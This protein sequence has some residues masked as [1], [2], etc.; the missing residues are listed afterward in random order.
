MKKRIIL[1]VTILLLAFYA[2]ANI[3]GA[4]VVPVNRHKKTS[5]VLT[6]GDLA[7][8]VI[9]STRNEDITIDV[10]VDS[11]YTEASW[12]VWDYTTSTYYFG[13]DQTFAAAYEN[14]VVTIPLALG[15]YSVHC[16]DAFGDGGIEGIVTDSDTNILVTW[17]AGDYLFSGEFD[18]TVSTV[19]FTIDLTDDFG[20]GWNGGMLDLSVNG[21]IVLDDITL[22]TGSGPETF[23]FNV[24]DDDFVEIYYTAGGWPYENAYYVY[25]NNGNLA[26]SSGDGGVEPDAYI[27]FTV[28]I[29]P[30]VPAVFFSEYIE[31]SSNNKGFEIYNNEGV[32][33]NL[34]DFRVN[35]SA[36]GGGWEYQHYFPVGA[37]LDFID[38]WSIC[39]DEADPALQAVSDEILAYPSVVH[40]NGNDARG[41]EW[42]P[43]GGVTWI[44]IDIIGIPDEDPGTGW[45]VAG[46]AD[47]TNDHTL[48]R[49]DAINAGNTDWVASAGTEPADSEWLV[50]IQDTYDY[51]GWH[52][53]PPPPPPNPPQNLFVDELGYAT[54]E[55]PAAAPEVIAHHNGYS[56]LG[57]GTGASED[58]ICAAR[59]NAD[60][61]AAYYDIFEITAVSVHIRSADFSYV[62]IKVW[63]GGSFGD[64]GTEVYSSDITNSILIEDWTTHTLIT[65]IPLVSG[66]EYWIG[67]DISVTGDSPSSIDNGPAISGKG[68]WMYYDGD[69]LELL[70]F[71]FNYNWCI[72]GVI[73]PVTDGIVTKGDRYMISNTRNMQHSNAP[74]RI[75]R[76]YNTTS[77]RDFRDLLGYNIYLDGVF[78]EYTT[79]LF[80]QYTGLLA[81][82]TYLSEVT[83]VYDEG[84]SDPIEY[85]FVYNP[86]LNPPQNLDV[87]CIE[88][89]AHFIWEAP[90]VDTGERK[91]STKANKENN[92]DLTGYSVYLDQIEVATNI[93]DLEYDFY[94]LIYGNFYDAGVKAIY[95]EGASEL[96]EI[97]FQYTGT[98]VENILP[99][100]TELTG[101][102][103]NPFNPITII[104]YSLAEEGNIELIVFNIKGQQVKTLINEKLP[105]GNHQVMWDGKDEY[106]KPVSSGIYFYKMNTSDYTSVKKMILMK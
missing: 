75:E 37:T 59:F 53:I 2:F 25:D 38:V 32:A 70:S 39:T 106:S 54:W 33:I 23:V 62:A 84:E 85:S 61:L 42:T 90:V 63:E 96:I 57:V 86:T 16:W 6:K 22:A 104:N 35:Q 65:P 73:A 18:F 99:F 97:N 20:D 21:T 98:G 41:L 91:R 27:S 66:N 7:V 31:G 82:D 102:Y 13:V 3:K 100:I 78:V 48:V 26:I 36:N 93:P 68:D 12:N 52:I 103:P 15:D 1:I 80:Y 28:S 88:D 46:I 30:P 24:A 10:T 45:S 74:L 60:E 92:R 4:V 14:V 40:Y 49:K 44:L 55:V 11:W 47:A 43:D 69:W 81:S 67:Y 29:A 8:P 51:F 83:A 72:E 56:G 79:D 9:R 19:D 105:A 95:D 58:W 71:G 101:N 87:A 89:H 50:H 34:D 94:D 64:P 17:T 5:D 76:S 77:T